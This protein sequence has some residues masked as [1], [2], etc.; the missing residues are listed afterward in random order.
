MN[1][2]FEPRKEIPNSSPRKRHQ[3]IVP[4]RVL[5]PKAFGF[6]PANSLHV[7][8][9]GTRASSGG[10][11]LG[12]G[13]RFVTASTPAGYIGTMVACNL[14]MTSRNLVQ[15]LLDRGKWLT[16]VFMYGFSET[17]GLKGITDPLFKCCVNNQSKHIISTLL[18]S[19]IQRIFPIPIVH[20][21]RSYSSDVKINCKMWFQ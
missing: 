21:W 10:A 5:S 8:Y 16:G 20:V 2:F 9:I 1:M 18:Y 12:A 11:Y 15:N 3:F 13:R 17:P 4:L 19:L 7:G 6:N 14:L